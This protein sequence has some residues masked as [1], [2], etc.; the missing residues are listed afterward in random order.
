MYF[1]KRIYRSIKNSPF[2]Q[3]PTKLVLHMNIYKGV[4]RNMTIAGLERRLCS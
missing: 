2:S 3:F 4:P 1:V